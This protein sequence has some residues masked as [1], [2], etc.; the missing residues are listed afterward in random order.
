[1]DYLQGLK[2]VLDITIKENASDLLISVDHPPTIR[3]TGQLVPLSKEKKVT[4]EDAKGIAFSLMDEGKKNKFLAEKE[5]DFSYDFD[6]KARFR[7]NIFFQRGRISLALRL[8]SPNI[9][10][11]EDLYL[12]AVLH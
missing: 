12:P 5:I 10:T 1:M 3:I 4:A 11:I 7:V 6:S 8:I 2:K 9:K